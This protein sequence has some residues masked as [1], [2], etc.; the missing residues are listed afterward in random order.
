MCVLSSCLC[1]LAVEMLRFGVTHPFDMDF[2]FG[3]VKERREIVL[4]FVNVVC[5]PVRVAFLFVVFASLK[6]VIGGLI[7]N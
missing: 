4:C 7:L 3:V 2:C 6:D 1:S 5:L